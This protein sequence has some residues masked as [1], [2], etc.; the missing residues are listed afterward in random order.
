VFRTPGDTPLTSVLGHGSFDCDDALVPDTVNNAPSIRAIYELANDTFAKYSVPVLWDK[1]TKTIVNNESAEII[2]MFNSEFND[3]S[4]YPTLNLAPA[5]LL[6][7]M[8]EYDEWIYPGIN[9]GVYKCGFAQSQAAYEDAFREL[10][11]ALDRLEEILSKRRYLCGNTLTLSDVR[12]F[13]TLVRFDEVYAVYFKTNKT[14]L[15]HGYPNIFNYTKDC[16]QL[17]GVTKTVNMKHIKM[18][19]YTSH[20]TLNTYAIIPHGNPVD[21]SS[22]HDRNRFSL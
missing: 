21:F 19:Y 6:T 8:K 10:F 5:S 16:Y 18:H 1:K 17:P 13:V 7:Q 4:K 9:N 11:N 3:L 20:P 22:S 2:D 14:T 15:Q 12:L